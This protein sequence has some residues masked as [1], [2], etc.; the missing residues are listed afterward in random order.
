MVKLRNLLAVIVLSAGPAGACEIR[1]FLTTDLPAMAKLPWI[2]ALELAYPGM[3]VSEDRQTLT[4]ADGR[5]LPTGL[6]DVPLSPQERL[7]DAN[8][9]EQ[10]LQTYPLAFDLTRREEPWFDPGRARNEPFFRALYGDS[11]EEV[12]ASLV[13]VTWPGKSK[14]SFQLSDRTCAATQLQAALNAIAA[15]GPDMDV[16]FQTIGGSFNWRAIA[17]TTRLSGHSFGMA[18]DFNTDLGGYWRWSGAAEGAVGPYENR[19][20]EVLVRE[21]ERHGFIWGGKWHHFDGMHFEYRPELILHA[22]LT[23]NRAD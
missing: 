5:K 7:E 12:A 1:D 19:Y 8:I 6:G 13:T 15:P 9:S 3:E 23:G 11:K 22:R 2:G 20:P 21:M 17:G 14:A 4:L 10:F 18:V 16:Y